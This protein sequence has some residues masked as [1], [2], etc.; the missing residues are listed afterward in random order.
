MGF[1]EFM[2]KLFGNKSQ[3]DLK[4][5]KPFVDKIKVAYGEI[6]R[7]SDDDLRGRTAIL[8]QKI[9]DYVKDERA[10]IDKLKV[11]VEGKDL[12]E[13]EEIWAK[14]DKLEK[15]FWTKWKSFWMKFSPKH[16]LLSKILLADSPKTKL[17]ESKPLIL[18]VTSQSTMISS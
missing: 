3:R 1:N 12:D 14:V 7:L 16:L 4:E 13:R 6:E 11:E 10:E 15:R 9:Q 17:F 2:S 8:R 5:V 18:I